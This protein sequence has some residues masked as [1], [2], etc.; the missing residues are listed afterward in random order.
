MA[1]RTRVRRG[2]LYGIVGALTLHAPAAGAAVVAPPAPAGVTE[3]LLYGDGRGGAQALLQYV[4]W[5]RFCRW[6]A[7]HHLCLHLVGLRRFCDRRPDHPLCDDDHD[8]FCRRH[9]RHPR[10]DDKPPS[11]S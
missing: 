3:T 2:L 11:P 6:H 5:D 1:P 10:C 4:H 8:L 9:P 7:R